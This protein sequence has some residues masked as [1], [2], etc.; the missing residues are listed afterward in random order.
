MPA[1]RDMPEFVHD[2]K[3]G[4]PVRAKWAQPLRPTGVAVRT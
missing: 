4:A 2:R 1:R 3:V